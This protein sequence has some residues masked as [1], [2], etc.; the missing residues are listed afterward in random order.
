MLKILPCCP[1]TQYRNDFA[2]L[3]SLEIPEISLL[4]FVLTLGS[5]LK[6]MSLISNYSP[7]FA[8]SVSTKESS[9]W[10][11]PFVLTTMSLD[12]FSVLNHIPSLSL[13]TKRQAGF[14]YLYI[15]SSFKL[16]PASPAFATLNKFHPVFACHCKRS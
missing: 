1:V 9:D 10:C 5:R 6:I 2:Q 14:F 15:V 12:I 16:S 7:C 13:L 3:V 11:L 8:P 4:L